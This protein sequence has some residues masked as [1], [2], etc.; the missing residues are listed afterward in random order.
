MF[1]N[2]KQVTFEL[3]NNYSLLYTIKA[4]KQADSQK[5]LPFM[6][7]AHLD[8]VPVDDQDWTYPPFEASIHDGYVYARGTLDNKHNVFVRF[9]ET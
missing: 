6:L 1:H 8:V 7:L 3:I 9:S 2:N 4:E 5:R